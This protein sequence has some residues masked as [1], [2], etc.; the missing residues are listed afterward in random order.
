MSIIFG[1]C[2]ILGGIF[3]MCGDLLLDIK[4]KENRPMGKYGIMDSAW[5]D[6]DIRR[7]RIS[8]LFAMAGVPLIF[9]G[10]TAMSGQ[11]MQGNELFGQIFWYISMVGS[12]GAFFIHTIICV[13]PIIYKTMR[14]HHS[15]E[16]AEAVINGVYESVRLPFWILY[17]AFVGIPSILLIWAMFAGYLNLSPWYSLLTMPVLVSVGVLLQKIKFDWFC[18]LPFVITP[19]LSMSMIGLMV[20]LNQK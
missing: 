5:D 3:T 2:G 9:L 13:F 8:I 14:P 10:L 4:G 1:V 7:F 20:I 18:D 6:M 17:L 16:E 19:S 15:F 12:T 11:L